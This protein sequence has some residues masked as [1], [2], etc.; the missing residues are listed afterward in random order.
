MKRELNTVIGSRKLCVWQPA[1]GVTWIQT[2]SAQFARKL[3]QR[4][5]SRLIVRGVVGGYL[6]TFEFHHSL[7]WACRLIARYTAAE[8][9]TNERKNSPACPTN[10][11][12][13]KLDS[14]AR[15]HP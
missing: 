7:A 9:P 1:P 2:R 10:A 6:R 15:G 3:S 4:G 14:T 13:L 12:E 8:T 5:D 11:P